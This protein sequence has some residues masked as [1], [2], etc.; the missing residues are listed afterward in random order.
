MR[1]LALCF[2]VVVGVRH[3]EF[4]GVNGVASEFSW[5]CRNLGECSVIGDIYDVD[6]SVRSWVFAFSSAVGV[7]VRHS[8]FVGVYG[9]A[10]GF[11]GVCLGGVVSRC[12]FG[13]WRSG[14]G[15]WGGAVGL[16][17]KRFRCSCRSLVML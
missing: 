17:L 12:V 7:W 11:S 9:G 6:G 1:L 5:M 3:N 10:D 8:V 16:F 13:T 2:V 4:V 14:M 15:G